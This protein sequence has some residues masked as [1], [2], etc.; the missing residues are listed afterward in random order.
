MLSSEDKRVLLE[1]AHKAIEH[2]LFGSRS[3]PIIPKS[4]SLL[5]QKGVFVTLVKEGDLRGCIGRVEPQHPLFQTVSEMA[6]A[7]A[8]NDPRF[9]PLT[10]SELPQITIEISVLSPLGRLTNVDALQIGRDGLVVRRGFSSGLLLP[11]VASQNRWSAEEFLSQ[12]CFKAG[13]PMDAW[14]EPG[15][16][17]FTF[18]AEV[19]SEGDV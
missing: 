3:Q 11:Q 8:F 15:T 19:F 7:A 9:P 18:S 10:V 16:E 4:P 12:V 13:L 6:Q 2:Q 17:L 5:A 1:I 14:Q